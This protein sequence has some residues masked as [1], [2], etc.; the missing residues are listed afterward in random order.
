MSGGLT[1]EQKEDIEEAFA[2]FAKGKPRLDLQGLGAFMRHLGQN[3][4]NADLQQIGGLDRQGALDYFSRRFVVEDSEADVIK[5]FIFFFPL[6]SFFF[7]SLI[8]PPEFRG[9]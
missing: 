5:V 1:D 6:S 7:V 9:V 3:L 8:S 4:S 2:L